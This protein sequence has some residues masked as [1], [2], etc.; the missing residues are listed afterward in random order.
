MAKAAAAKG[1]GDEEDEGA[2][3]HDGEDEKMRGPIAR[4]API[5]KDDDHRNT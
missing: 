3:R 4:A 2:L 5:R 1:Y